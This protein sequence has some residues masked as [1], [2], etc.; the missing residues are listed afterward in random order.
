MTRNTRWA[1]RDAFIRRKANA[2]FKALE[3]K[4]CDM[5]KFLFGDN[6]PPPSSPDKRINLSRALKGRKFTDEH[7]EKISRALKEHYRRKEHELDP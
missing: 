6:I 5:A 4:E 2:V 3:T 7:K 1:E